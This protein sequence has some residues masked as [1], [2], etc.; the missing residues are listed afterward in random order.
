MGGRGSVSYFIFT[1]NPNLQKVEGGAR[2][3]DFFKES[4]SKKM[5]VGALVS[6]FFTNN[7]NL[8]KK[9]K[10]GVQGGG[11]L[12]KVFCNMNPNLK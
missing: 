2:V 9:K 4:K 6:I 10:W 12:E 7:L 8:N 11:G 3:C 5:W 1:K